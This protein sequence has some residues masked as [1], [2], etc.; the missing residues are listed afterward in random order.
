MGEWVIMISQDEKQLSVDGAGQF[1]MVF[2]EPQTGQYE[3]KDWESNFYHFRLRNS[4]VGQ[5]TIDW[6]EENIAKAIIGPNGL[7][8][9]PE[10]YDL[11]RIAEEDADKTIKKVLR[12][13]PERWCDIPQKYAE[14]CKSVDGQLAAIASYGEQ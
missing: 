2:F 12:L 6:L 9:P 4:V 11:L 13:M 3:R 8:Y 7:Q 14:F 1:A 5:Y 10:F